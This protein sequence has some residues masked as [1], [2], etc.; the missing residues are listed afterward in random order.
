MRQR[1]LRPDVRLL[2]LMGPGG[3]G[4][5]RLGL[6][7]AR[8]VSDQ[9]A[10]GARFVG[11]APISDPALVSSAIAQALRVKQDAEQSVAEALE[12]Y[13][14]DRQLL[15]VLDNFERLLEA[16]PPIAQLLAD[17]THLKVLVTSRG[18]LHLQGEHNYEVPTLTLPPAG[19]RLAPEELG[20][21]EGI[22]LFMQRAQAANTRFTITTEN[23]PS[24]VE[25]CRQLDGLPLAIE[26]A[27]ARAKFL[28]PEAVLARLG[29]RLGLLTGGAGTCRTGSARSKQP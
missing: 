2:T 29:N 7:V 19:D 3:V 22:R 28:P 24:V 17:C 9:F 27:A 20:R 25:L 10:E 12:R 1:L 5:T 26:L 14:R 16:G 11:L 15:L 18:V 6:E 13:L 21:Y 8:R 23:S 4:K